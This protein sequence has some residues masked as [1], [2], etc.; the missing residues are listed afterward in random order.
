MQVLVELDA[1]QRLQVSFGSWNA[2]ASMLRPKNILELQALNQY[3]YS[4]N[5]SRIQ[6]KWVLPVRPLYPYIIYN[7]LYFYDHSV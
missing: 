2:I 7:D 1:S 6:T 5:I 4:T 3:F